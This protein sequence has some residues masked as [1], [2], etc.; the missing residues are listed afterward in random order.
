MPGKH[1]KSTRE[2]HIRVSSSQ[3]D[4]SVSSNSHKKDMRSHNN[5]IT[6]IIKGT[7]ENMKDFY[8]SGAN[9]K[10]LSAQNRTSRGKLRKRCHEIIDLPY[11]P[12]D[13]KQIMNYAPLSESELIE[14]RRGRDR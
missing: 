6:D 5:H 4:E 14:D 8:R 12:N 11:L 13:G 2:Q 10:Y 3:A 7:K 1:E 9:T